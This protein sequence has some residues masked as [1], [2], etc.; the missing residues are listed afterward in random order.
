LGRG[1]RRNGR[2]LYSREKARKDDKTCPVGIKTLR[3][4]LYGMR[5]AQGHGPTEPVA[6]RGREAHHVG[7]L[8]RLAAVASSSISFLQERR[9]NFGARLA[10]KRTRFTVTERGYSM[11]SLTTQWTAVSAGNHE[12]R[13][14][15]SAVNVERVSAA[16][17]RRVIPMTRMKSRTMSFFFSFFL[18]THDRGD[19]DK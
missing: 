2:G 9:S 19:L 8:R 1:R 17:P 15:T 6:G 13:P 11:P 16:G 18:R 7:S 3:L 5:R 4:R 14:I 10:R 12:P